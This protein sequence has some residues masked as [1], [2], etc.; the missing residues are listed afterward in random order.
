[1]RAAGA[2]CAPAPAASFWPVSSPNGVLQRFY[3]PTKK[4]LS[5]QCSVL[6]HVGQSAAVVTPPVFWKHATTP[7]A[8]GASAWMRAWAGDACL[9]EE[10]SEDGAGSKPHFEMQAV[11][12]LWGFWGRRKSQTDSMPQLSAACSFNWKSSRVSYAE[13][14]ISDDAGRVATWLLAAE[15]STVRPHGP[16]EF[17]TGIAVCAALAAGVAITARERDGKRAVLH[18]LLPARRLSNATQVAAW[19]RSL[20]C[21]PDGGSL[22]SR[23]HC[24]RFL[25]EWSSEKTAEMFG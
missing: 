5:S 23:M 1:M 8:T 10:H 21:C 11:L 22:S 17:W 20:S 4:K 14:K 16:Y 25:L 19:L 18:A 15:G 12:L 24:S 6:G 7:R 3:H 9:M 13:H 2:E